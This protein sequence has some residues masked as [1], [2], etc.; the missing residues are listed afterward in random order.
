MLPEQSDMTSGS[1]DTFY[2]LWW[3][4]V[5]WNPFSI[6]QSYF[7]SYSYFCERPAHN[8]CIHHNA[9]RFTGPHERIC[10]AVALLLDWTRR[11]FFCTPTLINE[12]WL[13]MS[14]SLVHLLSFLGPLLIHTIL[15]ENWTNSYKVVLKLNSGSSGRYHLGMS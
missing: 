10:A 6:M 11:V 12:S 1:A 14:L 5:V 9:E 2:E 13:L 7:K 4:R 3:K 15:Y 8:V